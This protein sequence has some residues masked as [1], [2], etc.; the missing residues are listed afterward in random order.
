MKL[1]LGCGSQTPDGWINVDYALGARLMK[2]PLFGILNKYLK[3]FNL[4]WDKKIFLHDLEKTL[5]WA[6]SSID[7]VYSSHTLEHFSKESGRK[8]LSESYRVL[9]KGGIVRII[10]PDLQSCITEYLEGRVKAEDFTDSLG[11]L[12]INRKGYVK[13]KLA[14][15]I[16][17]PHKCMYD[18]SSLVRILTDIGFDAEVKPAF[19]SEIDDINIIEMEGRTKNAVIVEGYK[20]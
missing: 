9:R 1:N 15:F 14:P 10:V 16:Q 8:I 6:D 13:N 19:G 7:A 5:P 20:R 18:S 2:V 3:L 17:F 12:F 4:D 11:V